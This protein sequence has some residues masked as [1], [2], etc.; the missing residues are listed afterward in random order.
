MRRR[1]ISSLLVAALIASFASSPRSSAQDEAKRKLPPVSAS[2]LPLEDLHDV[3]Y[4]L[5]LIK[6]QAVDIYAEAARLKTVSDATIQ[7]LNAIPQQP[8]LEESAYKPLR[9]A[10]I[11]FFIGT[12]EPLVHLLDEGLKDINSGAV[13][14]KVP[15]AKKPELD[16]MTA[17]IGDSLAA[18]NKH[19]N[20]CADVLDTND[21]DN[22]IIADQARAIAD[23]VAKAED[24]RRQAVKMFGN[25]GE[26][27]TYEMR[28]PGSAGV[29][30]RDP[31][32]AGVPPAS[33]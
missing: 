2:Q 30:P 22:L 28:D 31:G 23:E 9:K 3:G 21:S 14:L 29:P 4:I 13:E 11:V 1:F 19:L 6:Q 33:K 32:S 26:P 18:I 5:L 27:G 17:K 25:L 12:M 8:R 20:T 24:V 7:P 16:R 15:V 10:W